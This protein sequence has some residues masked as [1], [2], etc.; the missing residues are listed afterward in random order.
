MSNRLSTPASTISI[1]PP[2]RAPLTILRIFCARLIGDSG[3][4][5]ED[6]V[7]TAIHES[8]LSRKELYI[9]TKYDWGPIQKA[10]RDSLDKV[11]NDTSV[12]RICGLSVY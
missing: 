2:V 11:R 8:G 7:G 12:R 4:Y 9:T 3:Y 1:P 10:V 6:Q 5:N